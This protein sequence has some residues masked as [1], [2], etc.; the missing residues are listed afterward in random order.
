MPPE[1][2]YLPEDRRYPVPSRLLHWL[3]AVLLIAVWPLGMVIKFINEDAKLSFYMLHE[4]LGFLILWLMLARLAVRLLWPP[5][6]RP[7]LPLWQERV[8]ETVHALLYVALIAQP[9]IGFLTTN[10]FG[11]PLDWFGLVTV[12]SP[13]GRSDA[14]EILKSIHIFLGWSILALFALHIGGVLQHHV[15]RRDATLQRML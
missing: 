5:P 8:A 9:A 11:F 12:W 13:I 3:V 10:A 15:L 7:P 6:P 14:A 1:D 4:S 2:A